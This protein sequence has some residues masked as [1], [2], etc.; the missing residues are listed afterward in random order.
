MLSKTRHCL[1]G[2]ATNSRPPKPPPDRAFMCVHFGNCINLGSLPEKIQWKFSFLTESFFFIFII[3]ET[4]WKAIRIRFPI[5]FSHKFEQFNCHARL[6]LFRQIKLHKNTS[7]K[8]S[9]S[10]FVPSS[11][12]CCCRPTGKINSFPNLGKSRVQV[13]SVLTLRQ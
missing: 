3:D 10:S 2:K 7:R 13:R 6:S 9:I 1:R 8:L 4:V 11:T 5:V 12:C